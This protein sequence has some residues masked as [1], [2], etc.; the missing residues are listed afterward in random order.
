M[1]LPKRIGKVSILTKAMDKHQHPIIEILTS[2]AI[3][4][5]LILSLG[6]LF[7]II[8]LKWIGDKLIAIVTINS[9][10]NKSTSQSALTQ[11]KVS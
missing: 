9:K 11:T 10:D 2:I 1:T 7:T 5:Y 3:V 6:S 8:L 4:I